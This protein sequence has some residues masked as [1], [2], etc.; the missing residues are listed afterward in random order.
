MNNRSLPRAAPSAVGVDADGLIAFLDAVHAAPDIELHS[1][2][3]LRHG[4]V[5]AEG[6]WHPYSAERVHL[7]YSLSK[8]FT[9]TAAGFAVTEGHVDLDATVLSYFPELDS[10]ISDPRSRSMLV[11]HATRQTFTAA[12]GNDQPGLTDVV[13]SPGTDGIWTATLVEGDAPVVAELGIGAWTVTDVVAASG[14]WTTSGDPGQ[15]VIA[16]DVIF[17]ETPHRLQLRCHPSTGT[18][19]CRWMTMPLHSPRLSELRMPRSG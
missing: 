13:L 1:L 15:G 5:V 12:P 19:D 14:G 17:I 10:D 3:M 7:L 16:V 18:F 11:R 9:S 2:M 8:S 4:Q 6:W